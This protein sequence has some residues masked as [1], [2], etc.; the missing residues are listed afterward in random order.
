MKNVQITLCLVLGLLLL[1]NTMVAQ[2]AVQ[3]SPSTETEPKLKAVK[4]GQTKNVHQF[5]NFYLAGQ[6]TPDDIAV[7]K[8]AGIDVVISL[9]TDG[10]LK[11]DEKAALEKAGITFYQVPF[12][13]P[14]SLTDKVFDSVR[15]LLKTDGKEKKVMLHCG[16]ANRVGAVWAA[17]RALDQGQDPD[18]AIAEAKKV[19]LRYPPYEARAKEYIRAHADK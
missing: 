16:S 17:F 13:K 10:E 9:R 11:W 8:E 19:G 14:D 4:L 15:K 5:G 6:F 3:D 2:T 7:L 1:Q 18:E 12:R